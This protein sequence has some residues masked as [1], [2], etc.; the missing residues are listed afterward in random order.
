MNK[1]ETFNKLIN[2]KSPLL[3]CIFKTLILQLMVLSLTVYILRD[4]QYFNDK[5]KN[6]G[7]FSFILMFIVS[8]VLIISMMAIHT[9]FINKLII[10][11]IFGIIQGI[12]LAIVTKNLS[13]EII[14][15]AI[16]STFTI[17]ISFLIMGTILVYFNIDLSPLGIILFF[18]LLGLIIYKIIY[19]FQKTSSNKERN[20][21]LFTIFL[22]SIF[23]LYD[24]NRILLKYENSNDN[25]IRGSLDYYLDILNI[26]VNNLR[27]R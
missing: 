24:T 4:N 8:I 27:R 2:K 19:M 10:F 3:K 12:F 15:S 9:K 13:N 16:L 6:I 18:T 7:M 25:C 11:M 5:I 14:N 23:I 26:F 20:I 22:F 17:F 1:L 21:S